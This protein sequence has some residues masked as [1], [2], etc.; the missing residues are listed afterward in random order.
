MKNKQHTTHHACQEMLDKYGGKTIGCCCT[1]H[2]CK[3]HNESW[4]EKFNEK[5]GDGVD[6]AEWALDWDWEDVKAF[7]SQTRK[8]AIKEVLRI[9]EDSRNISEAI[10]KVEKYEE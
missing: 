6:T 10:R 7:I 9:M 1:G 5:F 8:E 3:P 4:E 2:S